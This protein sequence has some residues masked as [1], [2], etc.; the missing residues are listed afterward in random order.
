ML[1]SLRLFVHGGSPRS[2][3]AL[4]NVVELRSRLGKEHVGLEIVDIGADPQL[5]ERAKILATPTLLRVMPLPAIRIVGDFADLDS[6]TNLLLP[7]SDR[8]M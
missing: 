3:R 4:R 6:L 5:A 7:V 2:A 1:L 8:P